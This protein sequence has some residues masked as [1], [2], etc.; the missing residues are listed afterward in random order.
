MSPLR[1]YRFSAPVL[2]H[3][4]TWNC[5]MLED[6][7]GAIMLSEDSIQIV[8]A[9]HIYERQPLTTEVSA[10]KASGKWSLE[11]LHMNRLFIVLQ[12]RGYFC[13]MRRF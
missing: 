2:A 7:Q 4:S 12:G 9:V 8:I 13:P 6:V 11:S 5:L 1:V 10:P 3:T